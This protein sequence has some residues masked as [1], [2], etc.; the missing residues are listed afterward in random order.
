[1]DPSAQTGGVGWELPA[2]AQ[3]QAGHHSGGGSNSIVQHLFLLGLI[4]LPLLFITI[5]ID[6]SIV[7]IISVFYFVSIIKAREE[8]HETDSVASSFTAWFYLLLN[9]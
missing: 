9:F 2:A 3:G 8:K 4:P 1:M 6:V 7:N 5:I